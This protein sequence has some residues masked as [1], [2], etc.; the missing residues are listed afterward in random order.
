MSRPRAESPT[1]SLIR[2]GARYS[3]QFWEDGTAKRV[4]CGTADAIEAREFLAE[5]VAGLS[6]PPVP[7]APTIGDMLTGYA[8]DKVPLVGEPRVHAPATML[9][10]IN[11][12]TRHL[13]H[14]P[15][16]LFT[17]IQAR[18]YCADRRKEPQ[19]GRSGLYRKQGLSDGTLHRELG[20]LRA[21]L[22]W[23]VREGWIAHAP[24]VERPAGPPAR[25][26]WLETEEAAALFKACSHDYQRRFLAIA[27]Y[28]AARSSAILELTWDR[29]N[30]DRRTIDFGPPR[31][32][33]NRPRHQPIVDPLYALLIETKPSARSGFV[34]GDRVAIA[35]IKRGFKAITTR[36]GLTDVTP[37]ILRHTAVTWMMQA[38]VPTAEIAGYAAMA[39]ATVQRI[40]GHHSPDYMQHAVA[41]LASKLPEI[42]ALPSMP[43]MK[44]SG[45][46][47]ALG[48]LRG[49]FPRQLAR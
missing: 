41:A 42:G 34:I 24:Y 37:H 11:N 32:K 21:A 20:V 5:F 14:L 3:V 4:S 36:A 43:L 22:A 6:A 39:E 48:R 12:L 9:Y 25:E 18:Q 27:L 13:A 47:T 35:S 23:A 33:K 16:N 49:G 45:Q 30:L 40:Y 8:E 7:D 2:R 10:S 29:V 19:R 26:R 17:K 31:G 28:T 46:M 44:R 15:V 1:Y 38:G